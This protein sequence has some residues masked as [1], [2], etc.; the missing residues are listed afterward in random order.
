M[1]VLSWF[2]FIQA[3]NHA[4]DWAHCNALQLTSLCLQ[5]GS[6]RTVM[7]N[8]RTDANGGKLLLPR[9]L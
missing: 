7:F 5:A 2:A 3:A 6:I 1:G 8:E 9:V 4:I